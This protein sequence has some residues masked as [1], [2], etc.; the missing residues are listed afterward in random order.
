LP[1]LS[2][3]LDEGLLNYYRQ[4]ELKVGKYSNAGV[5]MLKFPRSFADME[6]TSNHRLDHFDAWCQLVKSY[7]PR[8]LSFLSDKLL[9]V[10]GLA[11]IM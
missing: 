11:R 9:A 8:D 10:A 5:L 3:E 7:S 2:D 4:I 6:R 1:S